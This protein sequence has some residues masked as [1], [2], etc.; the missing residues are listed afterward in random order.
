[1][2]K[3]RRSR[4]RSRSLRDKEGHSSDS[5]RRRSRTRSRSRSCI[6]HRSR[7]KRSAGSRRSKGKK[8]QRSLD[9]F[10]EWCLNEGLSTTYG[11]LQSMRWE[12]DLEPLLFDH[13]SSVLVELEERQA[14]MDDAEEENLQYQACSSSRNMKNTS[15]SSM[16]VHTPD[17]HAVASTSKEYETTSQ[18]PTAPKKSKDG[19]TIQTVTFQKEKSHSLKRRILELFWKSRQ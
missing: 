2:C 12:N 5:D 1:M 11:K 10:E 18:M 13:Y 16:T 8:L 7:D 6:E 3:S 19:Q 14:Q 4:S 9:T 15:M 17:R